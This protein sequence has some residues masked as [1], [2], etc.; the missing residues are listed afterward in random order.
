MVEVQ[1]EVTTDCGVVSEQDV[2]NVGKNAY[3]ESFTEY[4]L[5]PII[6]KYNGTLLMVDVDA[7][8]QM[9]GWTNGVEIKQEDVEWYE[10]V[11]SIDN[12]SHPSPTDPKDI[13]LN[14]WGYYLTPV[15]QGDY[16][17]IIKGKLEAEVDDC[18]V[19]ARTMVVEG[20]SGVQLQPNV[21]HANATVTISGITSQATISITDI[22]G[23]E[24]RSGVSVSGTFVAPASAGTY[25]VTILY[26]GATMHRTLIVCP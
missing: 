16:Y 22:Y 8:C 12:L 15:T 25:F 23:Y 1:C 7:V 21:V 4:D 14:K 5:L 2:I 3:P 11:D 6:S 26:G 10:R 9:F 17:A 20:T 24:E 19:W 13:P 18:G